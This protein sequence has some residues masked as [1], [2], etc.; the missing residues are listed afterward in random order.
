[1]KHFLIDY[2]I[3]GKDKHASGKRQVLMLFLF[4]LFFRPTTFFIRDFVMTINTLESI[5]LSIIAL[6]PYYYISKRFNCIYS[7]FITVFL[8][9]VLYSFLLSAIVSPIAILWPNKIFHYAHIAVN[10]FVINI[11]LSYGFMIYLIKNSR[12]VPIDYCSRKL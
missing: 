9:S 1:M 3:L 7:I 12:R 6:F 5:I 8:Y 11:F 4:I 2:T 10:P